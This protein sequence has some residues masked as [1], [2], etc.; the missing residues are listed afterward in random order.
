MLKFVRAIYMY[1]PGKWRIFLA[2]KYEDFPFKQLL[3]TYLKYITHYLEA[4]F[5]LNVMCTDVND[6]IK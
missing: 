5:M 6:Q 4:G 1:D 3:I 2:R